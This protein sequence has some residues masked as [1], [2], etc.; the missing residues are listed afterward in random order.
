MEKGPEEAKS[1]TGNREF[2]QG[3][4]SMVL[5][6]ALLGCW[7]ILFCVFDLTF[8]ILQSAPK[9]RFFWIR[10][11]KYFHAP[12]IS[13]RTSV[14]CKRAIT[15]FWAWCMNMYKSNAVLCFLTRFSVLTQVK[16]A[17]RDMPSI[18]HLLFCSLFW[19]LLFRKKQDKFFSQ[20]LKQS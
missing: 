4:I 17:N 5:L 10:S 2:H 20:N 16:C 13:S 1:F 3:V 11:W 8:L 12:E 6:L 15:L 14:K 9:N 18:W 19:N 7:I